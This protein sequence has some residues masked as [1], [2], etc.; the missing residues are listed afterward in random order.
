MIERRFFFY[1]S[2]AYQAQLLAYSTKGS[3]FQEKLIAVALPD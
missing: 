1:S 3:L 2:A